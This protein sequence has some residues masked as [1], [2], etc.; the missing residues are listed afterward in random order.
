MVKVIALESTTIHKSQNS[1]MIKIIAG[2][3]YN[4][5]E[6]VVRTLGPSVKVITGA[7]NTAVTPDEPVQK[8]VT[9]KRKR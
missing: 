4:L 7:K 5:D 1:P 9:Q 6:E 8:T 2:N 3:E